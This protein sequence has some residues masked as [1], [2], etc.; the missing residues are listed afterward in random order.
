[1]SEITRPNPDAL[2]ASIQRENSKKT[3]GRLKVFFGMAPGVGKTYAMLK[4]AHQRLSEGVK[5]LIGVV[6]THNRAETMALLEGLE[7]L[8]RREIDYRG[9]RLEEMDLD[10][11]IAHKPELILVDE[12]AHTN[13]EG[14]RHPKRYQDVQEL[15]DLGIDVSTTM[16]VQHLE[17]RSDSVHQ[18]T[19]VP[20]YETV[21]DSVFDLADEIQLID[22]PPEQL[23]ERLAEGKV[24]LGE[25]AKA[26]SLNFFKGDN[27]TALRELSLRVTA[28]CVDKELRE[29][30]Q[31]RAGLSIWRSSEKFMVAVGPSPFSMQIV[32]HAR[33][34]ASIQDAQW[35][36]VSVTGKNPLSP[37]HQ[38]QLDKNL[39]LARDLGAEVILLQDEHVVEALI[40]TA[41][42]NNVTQVVLGQTHHHPLLRWLGGGSLADQLAAADNHLH[43]YLIPSGQ[44]KKQKLWNAWQFRSVSRLHEYLVSVGVVTA[45]TAASLLIAALIGYRSIAL[46]YLLGVIL[47]GLFVGR[48]PV[49]LAAVLSGLC[50]DY[51]FI[52]PVFTFVIGKFEDAFMLGIFLVV[53]LVTGQLTSRIRSKE[54]DERRREQRSQALYQLIRSIASAP[55]TEALLGA[56]VEKIAEVFHAESAFILTDMQGRLSLTAHRSSYLKL[57]EKEYGVASWAFLNR[58][59]A[60]RFTDSIPSAT[61]FHLPLAK[62]DHVVGVLSVRPRQEEPLSLDQRDLLES[63]AQQ[64]ALVLENE[65]LRTRSTQA[66]VWEKTSQLQRTLLNSISHELRTPLSAIQAASDELASLGLNVEQGGLLDEITE[67]LERLKRLVKNLLDSARLESTELSPKREWGEVQELVDEAVELAGLGS[68]NTQL[69][70]ILPENLPLVHVD[71][72]LIGQALANLLH[73]AVVHT[74]EGTPITLSAYDTEETLVLLVADEGPGIPEEFLPHLFEKFYRASDARPGG[75]GLGL[76]IARGFVQAHGGTVQAYNQTSGQGAVFIIRLPLGKDHLQKPTKS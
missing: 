28:E 33:R 6:E 11:I 36:A 52:P 50:W 66:E 55:T 38:Q 37:R 70:I 61:A 71:F 31:G 41:R 42:Q 14:S 46:L 57:D 48:G 75:T 19:G 59:I 60:G 9:I 54:R 1:M 26:A 68:R 49:L 24:Y 76:S 23:L 21:P 58:R 16:N 74:P 18:I 62:G 47:Q 72:G 17:S 65:L 27:L 45:L 25:R 29:I 73:N 34:L 5:V 30:R 44:M 64:L 13:A 69:W 22:L 63:F 2:L 35:L 56:A 39:T 3:R 7:V 15:L 32:R 20:V 40:R 4:D 51:L 10:S 8:P 43:F 53:A 12:L 67:A